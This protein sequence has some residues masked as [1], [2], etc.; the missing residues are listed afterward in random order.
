MKL[1]KK[2]QLEILQALYEIYP[3]YT[4]D[5]IKN[6]NKDQYLG[7]LY[8]LN[9]QGLV[10][11][12]L[13]RSITGA[14][15]F[16]GAAITSKGI[17]YLSLALANGTNMIEGFAN[18][19]MAV[20]INNNNSII[21]GSAVN[22]PIQHGVNSNLQQEI[23][24]DSKRRDESLRHLV[25]LLDGHLSQLNLSVSDERKAKSQLE[26]I[27]AQLLDK[28]NPSIVKEAAKT[29]KNITEG[30]IGSLIASA[31]QPTVWV[32]V[33]NLLNHFS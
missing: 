22:S 28:P 7:N 5:I 18:P 2:I 10:N 29:L 30:A 13:D 24:Y 23:V 8:Y 17:S 20:T 26:T 16:Q 6:D 27:K 9:E 32:T 19:D 11:A 4:T 25:E 33:L 31:I 21:I 1:D 14:F 3:D 15:L 12:S